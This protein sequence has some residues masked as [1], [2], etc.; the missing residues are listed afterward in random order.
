MDTTSA[1]Q[2]I[3]HQSMG[4]DFTPYDTKWIPGTAKFVL[5]GQTMKATGILKIFKLH[6][7]KCEEELSVQYLYHRS[8][9]DRVLRAFLLA[10][11]RLEDNHLPLEI[12]MENLGFMILKKIKYPGGSRHTERL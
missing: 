9:K 5:G 11:L 12:L 8:E 10:L 6:P 2:I 1:P 7:E 3:E 4:L